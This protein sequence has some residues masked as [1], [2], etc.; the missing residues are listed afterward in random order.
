MSDTAMIAFLPTNGSWCKQDFPHM[1]L[2][3]AG[4]IEDRP[5]TEFNEMAKDAISAAR[6]VKS[7][8]LNVVGVETLGD[9]G[10]EVDALM[11]FPTPQLLVAYNSVSSRW[12]KSEFRGNYLPH[13]TIGPA[14]SAYTQEDPLT[15]T[16][17]Y[18]YKQNRRNTLP[19]SIYFD[20]LAVC[21]GD[22]KMIF[23]LSD[24]DY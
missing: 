23:S 3:F 18:N 24:F 20:R 19:A 6:I 12:D 2:V 7:F 10:E 1:T 15:N 4:K 11:L 16:D 9:A 8:S 13:A 5:D 22:N 17:D 14:G 21:W